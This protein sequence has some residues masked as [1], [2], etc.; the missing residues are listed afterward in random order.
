VTSVAATG[1]DIAARAGELGLCAE[2]ALELE[3][4]RSSSQTNMVEFP[5]DVNYQSVASEH[6]ALLDIED[7]SLLLCCIEFRFTKRIGTHFKTHFDQRTGNN[8]A[9]CFLHERERVRRK[10]DH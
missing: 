1:D 5:V 10:S 2:L 8:E 4:L 3:G 6:Q 9:R 7:A